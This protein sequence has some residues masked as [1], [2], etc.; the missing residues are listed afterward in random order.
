MA[1]PFTARFH[2]EEGWRCV[3]AREGRTHLHV[4]F[5][6]DLGIVHRT[7]PRDGIRFLQPLMLRGSP[8]PVSRMVRKFREVGRERGI[9]EA[10]KAELARV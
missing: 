5:I 8:Y 6:S 1:D 2:D 4:T 10:A 7:E 3:L 9:T